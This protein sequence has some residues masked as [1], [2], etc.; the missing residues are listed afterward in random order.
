MGLFD[1]IKKF[2]QK[3]AGDLETNKVP[4]QASTQKYVKPSSYGGEFVSAVESPLFEVAE[5]LQLNVETYI[6]WDDLFV[7]GK[8]NDKLPGFDLRSRR[9]FKLHY[10]D[11]NCLVL[12]ANKILYVTGLEAGK[13]IHFDEHL[14]EPISIDRVKRNGATL[15]SENLAGYLDFETGLVTLLR[16]SW[17]PF[18][19]EIGETYWLVGTR[20][21]TEGPGELYCFSH[22]GDYLWGL[23]FR[24]EFET[25]LGTI[26]ATPYF[27]SISKNDADILVSTMDRLYKLSPDGTLSARISLSDLR[28]AEIK[29][30]ED[31]IRASL[32][33]NP[34]TKEEIIN[35]LATEMATQ[36]SGGMTR[37]ASLHSPLAGFTRDSLTGRIFIL[38][39][40][41]DKSI[42]TAWDSAGNLLWDHSF[43]E[44]NGN[45]INWLDNSVIVSLR[46]G[47]TFWL[48]PNGTIRLSAKLPKQAENI[49]E[50]PDQEKY[51]VICQD[52]RRYEFDIKTGDLIQGPEG[53]R[54]MSLFLFN[55]RMIFYD[56]Y[57]WAAPKG[58]SWQTYHPK[59]VD[60]ATTALDLASDES[61][62]Q[63]RSDKPFKKIWVYKNPNGYPIYHYAVDRKNNKL[64]VGRRKTDLSTEEKRQEMNAMKDNSFSAWNEVAC[65]DLS[66]NQ[67]WA[68]S[69]LSEL[70]SIAV[71]PDG[72]AIFVGLWGGGLAYDPG[73]LAIFD[74]QGNI[75]KV[76]DTA[77][78]PTTFS[79]ENSDYGI[80]E[81]SDGPKYKVQRDTNGEWSIRNVSKSLKNSENFGAGLNQISIGSFRLNRLNKRSYRLAYND[82]IVD[83]K[84]NAAI[85]EAVKIPNDDN[86]LLRIGYK[87]LRAVS[88]KIEILWELKTKE[89][90]KSVAVGSDGFLVLS[91][92]EIMFL[93][94][95]GKVNWRLG[96]PPNSNYN[97]ATWIS[98]YNAFLWGAGDGDYYQ[99]SL[100]SSNGNILKSHLFK[101]VLVHHGI[102]I[103][104]DG[105]CF[106]ISFSGY[107]EIYKLG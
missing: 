85:Y 11:F 34:E 9:K 1:R 5:T 33:K 107:I 94:S 27:L 44:G 71:S 99:I 101:D 83:L 47:H 52:G 22:K 25:M 45:Y 68:V 66:L 6:G 97:N 58:H 77:A 76:S 73:R 78:N 82:T 13:K 2:S 65:Y 41:I 54:K 12:E 32:P 3:G 51:L 30:K 62:P 95:E 81:V 14:S 87:S 26:K 8:K 43:Y 4:I 92:D 35:V 67:C 56:G 75:R 86:M 48:D 79:F 84:V 15:V 106:I 42:L 53:N 104:D 24:E 49:F 37:S 19:T 50:I 18:R 46:T 100:I 10:H 70:T 59:K 103:L 96:C 90:I 91:K 102:D 98:K 63:V 31:K 72:D 89:N 16:F 23:E 93:T 20:E 17:Q 105:S 69:F 55:D 61:A 57:L 80:F 88:P 38:D 74:S 60:H 7:R 29:N 36:L 21:T 39:G 64:Y 28:D 40:R